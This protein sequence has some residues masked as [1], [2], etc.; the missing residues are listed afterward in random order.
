[1]EGSAA[2]SRDGH[3]VAFLS[4]RDGQMD[5]WLTQVGSGMFHNLTRGSARELV[6]PLIR[7]LGFSPDGSLVTFW[8]RRQNGSRGDIRVWAMPTL[9]G[10]PRPYLEGVSEFDWSHDGS[11][12]AYHTQAPGDP[13]F[14]SDG[15]RRPGDRP[16]FAA[17]TGLHTHFP[18][19]APDNAF[20]YF[21]QGDPPG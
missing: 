5:V 19:W 20:V 14:V 16:I 12:L 2:V 8:V 15:T 18:L 3:F 9:G 13:L 6:V 10:E 4:D 7:A 1:V 17:P 11:R 21:V